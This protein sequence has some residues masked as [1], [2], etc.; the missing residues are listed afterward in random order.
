MSIGSELTTFAAFVRDLP[1]FLRKRMTLEEAAAIVRRRMAERPSNLLSSLDRGV[2]G[3]A[4]SPYLPL[5]RE[6]RCE[7]GDIERLLGESGVEATLHTL[8]E[9]GVFLTF[10]EFK[11]HRPIVRSNVAIRPRPADFDNPSFRRYYHTTTGGSTGAPRR[12]LMDLD[13]FR[14]RLP[15]A[16][17]LAQCHGVRG[18]PLVQWAEIPPGHGLEAAVV[19]VPVGHVPERWFTP[20]W[21]GSSSP[22]ARFRWATRAMVH[23]AR[24]AYPT[25]PKPEY[26]PLDR[27]DVI[28]RW[29]EQTLKARGPCVIRA[30]VSKALRIAVAAHEMGVDLTGVTITGGGEPPTVA[31]VR[32]ITSA[33]VRFLP[34]YFLM[35][36]GPIG[37]GCTQSND[38][39]DQH[40]LLDHLAMIPGPRH[41]PAFGVTVDAFYY[42]TLLPTA[43]KLMLN[44]ETDD[45][46]T[47][48]SRTCGCPFEEFGWTTHL[49]DI[50]SFSKLTGEGVTLIGGEMERILEDEL[51]S[52]FGGSALDYQLVEEEDERG[53]TRLTLFIDPRIDIADEGAVVHAMH[54]ALHRAGGGADVSRAIWSQA[55][56]LRVRRQTPRLSARGKLLPLHAKRKHAAPASPAGGGPA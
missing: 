14:A 44:V 52:R 48:E 49:R 6:A 25:F 8:R 18:L 46:G 21:A 33:G 47:V 24:R 32:Q 41:V 42:T 45:Y 39:N 34:T 31:K 19:G 17:V 35:E 12:V 2:F 38:P 56:S 10:E 51:P 53:F 3:N 4:R 43:P 5:L 1:A 26:L 55:G 16:L 30:H 20:M 50:R 27:A 54:D 15:G 29:A 13:H 11:G 22:G 9:A 36:A 28:V 37:F 7:R 40:L 23:V